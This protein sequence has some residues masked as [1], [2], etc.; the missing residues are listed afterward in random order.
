VLRDV[1]EPLPKR[2]ARRPR[3]RL[4]GGR[5]GGAADAQAGEARRGGPEC[6]R[7]ADEGRRRLQRSPGEA[8][9]GTCGHGDCGIGSS[10][11]NGPSGGCDNGGGVAGPERL[12]GGHGHERL[13][14]LLIA[15]AWG[16]AATP[17][18]RWRR[19]W[20]LG[21]VQAPERVAVLAP[22]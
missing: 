20:V 5:A 4:A 1:G 12:G 8:G 13:Q 21:L 19:R 2:Q 17:G 14:G 10:Q 9:D 15:A 11:G 6:H 3:A 7:G 22:A 16:A 18:H